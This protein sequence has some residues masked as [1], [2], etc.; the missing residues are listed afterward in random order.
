MAIFNQKK[1]PSEKENWDLLNCKIESR[2][3]MPEPHYEVNQPI[4]NIINRLAGV[5]AR[6][7]GKYAACY[8]ARCPSHDDKSASLSV[9][10]KSDGR[11]LMRCHAGCGIETALAAIGLTKRDL[12]PS[13]SRA[14][15]D[16]RAASRAINLDRVDTAL[17]VIN[18][19]AGK[20]D[21]RERFTPL[22]AREFEAAKQTVKNYLQQQQQEI[23]NGNSEG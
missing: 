12:F 2:R 8:Q 17:L 7:R 6:A 10:L 14:G 11:V 4:E 3:I 21:R 23:E 15:F 20:I 5:K 18:I 22:E 16:S 13:P 1:N 19:G 9:T